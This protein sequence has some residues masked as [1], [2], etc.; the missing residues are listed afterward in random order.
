MVVNSIPH[1]I[2]TSMTLMSQK[3][4]WERLRVLFDA[5]KEREGFSQASFGKK[6]GL[7]SQGMVWQY[8]WGKTPLNVEAAKK[9]ATALKVPVR[10]FSPSLA[11]AI[12][13]TAMF[14]TPKKHAKGHWPFSKVTAEQYF[15]VLDQAQRDAVEMMV[16]A[17]V[18]A[19]EPP[20]KQELPAN[21]AAGVKA[22]R[23]V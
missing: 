18:K 17:L 1:F 5:A 20:E 9:F 3:T 15:E 19:R 11:E 16:D 23:S 14:A 21:Y 8:L 2:L 10:E 7:G 13:N 22:A 6:H 12:E 4:D